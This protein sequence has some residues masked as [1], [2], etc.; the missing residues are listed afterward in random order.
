MRVFIGISDDGVRVSAALFDVYG[1]KLD[2]FR[3]DREKYDYEKDVETIFFQEIDKLVA[4]EIYELQTIGL[5]IEGIKLLK[6]HYELNSSNHFQEYPVAVKL[7]ERYRCG[8]IVSNNMN[9]C[10]YGAYKYNNSIEQDVIGIFAGEKVGGAIILG[11]N[12]YFGKLGPTELSH[13][14]VEPNGALCNCGNYGCLE[15]YTSRDAIQQYIVMQ[16]RKGRQCL[17]GDI[18]VRDKA[19]TYK[20]IAAAYKREDDIVMEAVD[21]ALKY[22]AI[23]YSNMSYICRPEMVIFGGELF[24]ELGDVSV[25]KL[26]KFVRQ[27]TLLTDIVETKVLLTD[28]GDSSAVYGAYR[29]AIDSDIGVI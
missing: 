28:L 21:R 14:T 6:G 10:V 2:G 27:Y 1:K 4:P 22:L 13:V 19:L 12:V 8:V 29:M 18:A 25:G 5:G 17:I 23:I 7:R 26:R 9:C 20:Q 3:I 16:Y 24:A 15:S 11:G